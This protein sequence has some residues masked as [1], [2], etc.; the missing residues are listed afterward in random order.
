MPHLLTLDNHPLTWDEL[1]RRNEA[2]WQWRE[3]QER[4]KDV[5][6]VVYKGGLQRVADLSD[7]TRARLIRLGKLR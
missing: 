3:E 6:M 5:P 1:H 4:I 2:Y 7:T